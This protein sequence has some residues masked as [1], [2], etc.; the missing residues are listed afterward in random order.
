MREK[1]QIKIPPSVLPTKKSNKTNKQKRTE[2]N[3]SKLISFPHQDIL[4]KKLFQYCS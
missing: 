2:L 3:K 4:P 1:K